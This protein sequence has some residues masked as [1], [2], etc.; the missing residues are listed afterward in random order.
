V[1]DLLHPA[2]QRKDHRVRWQRAAAVEQQLR[3]AAAVVECS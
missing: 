1:G 2:V 3:G